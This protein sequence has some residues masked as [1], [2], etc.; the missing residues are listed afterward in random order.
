MWL[1]KPNFD[2][3]FSY[4][5]GLQIITLLPIF[6]IFRWIVLSYFYFYIRYG[7]ICIFMLICSFIYASI[8]VLKGLL[9]TLKLRS[10]IVDFS[11]PSAIFVQFS[12]LINFFLYI[13]LY[14]VIILWLYHWLLNSTYLEECSVCNSFGQL[15]KLM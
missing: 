10:M 11:S 3:S 2:L 7:L 5:F 13:V 6:L 14:I 1:R 9:T 15:F 4:D 12:L 8:F